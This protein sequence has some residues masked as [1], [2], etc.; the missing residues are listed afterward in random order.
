MYKQEEYSKKLAELKIYF[1]DEILI[2]A[3]DFE[4]Y[5]F[6]SG[7]GILFSVV[8]FP[9]L[10]YFVSGDSQICNTER[11]DLPICETLKEFTWAHMNSCNYCN[12]CSQQGINCTILGKKLDN[13]LCKC[14][15]MF[16]NP[17]SETF[18]KLKKLEEAYKLCIIELNNQR[19][20]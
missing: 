12:G 1:N 5:L 13:N 2:N 19:T 7:Y 16:E 14:P 18:E 15:I 3:L 17:D 10:L 20:E 9:R 11:N 4:E 6:N 8:A